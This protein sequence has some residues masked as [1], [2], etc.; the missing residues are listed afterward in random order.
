MV[1]RM[2]VNKKFLGILVISILFISY[3]IALGSQTSILGILKAHNNTNNIFG[4]QEDVPPNVEITK[5]E[6]MTANI[7]PFGKILEKRTTVTFSIRNLGNNRVSFQLKDRI[8]NP[9]L[10][11]FQVIRGSFDKRPEVEF[12]DNGT[13][14]YMLIKF[15]NITIEPRS[16]KEFGYVVKTTSEIPYKISSIY[17]INNTRVY[18]N[19]SDGNPKIYAPIGSKITQVINLQ[20]IDRGKFGLNS[21]IRPPYIALLT[22]ILP[23]SEKEEEMDISEPEFS[24]PPIMQNFMSFVQQI[25]WAVL[26]NN[27]TVNWSAKILKGGGW[28]IL[29]IQ[30]MMLVISRSSEM[31]SSVLDAISGMLGV[32]AGLQGYWV[33][34]VVDSILEEFMALSSYLQYIFEI[35]SMENTIMNMGL[36]SMINNLMIALVEADLLKGFLQDSYQ[37]IGDVIDDI[38]SSFPLDAINLINVQNTLNTSMDYISDMERRITA[39]F[40]AQIIELLGNPAVITIKNMTILDLIHLEYLF[41]NATASELSNNMTDFYTKIEIVNLTGMGGLINLT[42]TYEYKIG[43]TTGFFYLIDQVFGNVIFA[44]TNVSGSPNSTAPGIY[45]SFLNMMTPGE[46][47]FWYT[48]GNISRSLATQLLLLNSTFGGKYGA[49]LRNQSA[50]V[51]ITPFDPFI[52]ET[53]F[54]GIDS[55]L[56]GIESIQ[57]QFQSPYGNPP[58]VYIPDVSSQYGSFFGNNSSQE[59]ISFLNN[60]SFNTQLQIYMNPILYVR[61]TLNFKMPVSDLSGFNITS[62]FTQGVS[63]TIA[64]YVLEDGTKP[65]WVNSTIDGYEIIIN[66]TPIYK[67]FIVN[68]LSNF[69][70]NVLVPGK[71]LFMNLR[72]NNTNAKVDL[73]IYD[74]NNTIIKKNLQEFL[75]ENNTWYNLTLDLSNPDYW[76]YYDRKFDNDHITRFKFII[77]TSRPIAFDIDY[78]NMTRTIL[79]YPN[80]ITIDEGYIYSEGLEPFGNNTKYTKLNEGYEIPFSF[81]EDVY[82][83]PDKEIILGSTD[84]TIYVYNGTT[85]R[86]LYNITLINKIAHMF[87]QDFYNNGQNEIIVGLTNGTL[88][89]LN[90]TGSVLMKYNFDNSIDSMVIGDVDNNA[91]NNEIVLGVNEYYLVVLNGTGQQLWNR[92]IGNKITKIE[93]TDLNMD[94]QSE[95]LLSSY[96]NSIKCFNSTDGELLWK[97]VFDNDVMSFVVGNFTG[98]KYDDIIAYVKYDYLFAF[99][100]ENRSDLWNKETNTIIYD[101]DV[102]QGTSGLDD[103]VMITTTNLTLVNGINGTNIWNKNINSVP[104]VLKVFDIDNDSEKEIIIGADNNNISVYKYNSSIEWEY[105][106]EDNVRSIGIGDIDNNSILDM[107][108]GQINNKI[109]AVNLTDFSKIWSEVIGIWIISFKFTRT[110]DE[111]SIYYNLPEPITNLM[112]TIGLNLPDLTSMASIGSLSSISST[113][114][115]GFDNLAGMSMNPSDLQELGGAFQLEG[116]GLLNLLI[117]ELNLMITLQEM[118]DVAKYDK[119]FTGVLD[120]RALNDDFIDYNVFINETGDSSNWKYIQCDIRNNEEKDITLQYFGITLSNE[121][122][123]IPKNRIIIQGYNVT[124]GKWIDIN[125]SIIEDFDWDLIGLKY[126]NGSVV[127]KNYLTISPD[128]RKCVTTDWKLRELRLKINL[129]GL[130]SKN[131]SIQVWVDCTEDYE[132][133]D[134]LPISSSITVNSIYPTILVYNIPKIEIPPKAESNILMDIITSP[135]TW[136]FIFAI[137]LIGGAN[138]YLNNREKFRFNRMATKKMLKWLKKKQDEWDEKLMNGEMNIKKYSGLL[139]MRLRLKRDFRNP[140]SFFMKFLFEYNK[141]LNSN[142]LLRDVKDIF[143]FRNFWRDIDQRSKLALIVDEITKMVII[144]LKYL[145]QGMFWIPKGIF[146]LLRLAFGKKKKIIV[147]KKKSLVDDSNVDFFEN[148]N[149]NNIDQ[150]NTKTS[151]ELNADIETYTN[152]GSNQDS[153]KEITSD[154]DLNGKTRAEKSKNRNSRKTMRDGGTKTKSITAKLPELET[155]LGRTFYFIAKNKYIGCTAKDIA[156]E[157]D[158]TIHEALFYIFKLYENGLLMQIHEG[159]TIADDVWDLT[160]EYKKFDPELEKIIEKIDNLYEEVSEGLIITESE[161]KSELFRDDKVFKHEKPTEATPIKQNLDIKDLKILMP[162][163]VKVNI[164]IPAIDELKV[165]EKKEAPNIP[166]SNLNLE[167]NKKTDNSNDLTKNHEIS[168]QNKDE[169]NK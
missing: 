14:G 22:I 30:P 148:N 153:T 77:N 144:P 94:N 61:N 57:K 19:K 70:K 41:V 35:M 128:E 66:D 43:N 95:I 110:N 60:I 151:A 55:F 97:K 101:M 9:I 96:A 109:Q 111:I 143:L 106:V 161:L 7:D 12:L 141:K 105:K 5:T 89:I 38:S 56:R 167:Q 71:K 127:F 36:Y 4:L 112:Q 69:S 63:I 16:R 52:L 124:S 17:Y 15:P 44:E 53:G 149:S 74:G 103:L 32:I 76:N 42:R 166:R 26:T 65:K 34:L 157:L 137:G 158:I 59:N 100:G 139:R 3:F 27:Y 84:N 155:K 118:S 13:Y 136:A 147:S 102:I 135:I 145:L 51:N 6:S 165:V 23:Y 33:G 98:D 39:S 129:T 83:G 58:D 20:R 50:N 81:I 62:N 107:C 123:P 169:I 54:H 80:N 73:K 10:D 114:L 40:G 8:E 48:L 46:G 45:T 82:G 64:N 152:K 150:N 164:E 163:P 31:T 85:G 156:K 168:E 90:G 88:L 18:L 91:S 130:P 119:A 28:G 29:E 86:Q 79:P 1:V 117:F 108:V 25:S 116:I 121:E 140:R 134:I 49:L 87:I 113:D 78:M 146:K 154:Q 93:I 122:N 2:K 162:T 75:L 47:S 159:K 67:R 115:N 92:T 21:I 160:P 133:I 24:Q 99:S 126:V 125:D 72:M 104:R 142:K 131:V 68:G 11:T 120:V 132:G 138:H 37:T